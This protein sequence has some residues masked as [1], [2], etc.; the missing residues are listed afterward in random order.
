[1]FSLELPNRGDSNEYTQHTII[2]IKKKITRNY[3]KY[4]NVCSYG[5]FLSGTQE[6]VRNSCGKQAI[7]VRATE[8]LLYILLRN[9]GNEHNL[10]CPFLR[11]TTFVTS[12]L[13][14]WANPP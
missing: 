11:E 10:L 1:M 7:S 13:L 3:S 9:I 5:T 2:N 14:S 6:R 4:N 8:V 12:S